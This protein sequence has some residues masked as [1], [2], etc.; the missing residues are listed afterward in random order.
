MNERDLNNL[1]FL[2][3]LK[4]EDIMDW[5]ITVG[6]DDV[7]YA[8]TLLLTAALDEIDAQNE[9]VDCSEAK[10]LLAQFMLPKKDVG[11][12]PAKNKNL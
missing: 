5:M 10:T 9:K 3:S 8:M 7:D 11:T 12:L 1:R 4:N 2:M 6:Q